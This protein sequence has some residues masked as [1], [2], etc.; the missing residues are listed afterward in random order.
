LKYVLFAYNFNHRKTRDFIIMMEKLGCNLDYILAAPKVKLNLPESKIRTSV[1]SK[2]YF[3]PK[4]IAEM[5][6]IPY[7]VVHHNSE[8][9]RKILKKRGADI[10]IISGARIISKDT[11][12]AFSYGIIN[13][14]PGIIPINRGLDNLKWAIELNIPQGITAHFI[15]KRVDAGRIILKKEI[16]IYQDDTLFDVQQRLYDTQLE[17]MNRERNQRFSTCY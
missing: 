14:H 12:D 2:E 13:F 17:L 16:P 5:F 9:C 7:F 3:H 8:E 6:D 10:G 1:K 11:I 15:D 4:E